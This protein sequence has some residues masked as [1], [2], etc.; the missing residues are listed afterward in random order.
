MVFDND[1]TAEHERLAKLSSKQRRR[2]S[3]AGWVPC[4]CLTAP[5]MASVLPACKHNPGTS[6]AS[7]TA[8]CMHSHILH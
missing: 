2:I 5:H 3:G 7:K 1:P 6:M 8:L 4:E